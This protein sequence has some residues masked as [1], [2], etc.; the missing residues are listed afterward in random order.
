MKVRILIRHVS[1]TKASQVEEVAVPDSGELTFGREPSCEVRF[2]KNQDDL[3][4]RRHMRMVLSGRPPEFSIA[5]LG[6]RNGTF[7]NKQRVSGT[8][9]VRPGPSR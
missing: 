2:D 3:V 7:I 6:S 5:D 1:G 8:A 9:P 4:S